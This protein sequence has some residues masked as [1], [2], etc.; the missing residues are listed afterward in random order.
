[1]PTSPT[2]TATKDVF[3]ERSGLCRSHSGINL[4]KKA[5]IRRSYS[6]NDLCYSVNRIRCE[7][8][9]PNLKN[10]LS[11]GIFSLQISSSIIPDSLKSFLYHPELNKDLS[12]ADKD[13]N[14]DENPAEND[15]EVNEIK[16][17]NWVDMLLEIQSLWKLRQQEESVDGAEICDSENAVWDCDDN[18]DEIGCVVNYDSEGGGSKEIYDRE[19]FSKLLVQGPWSDT[20]LF[21]QLAFLCNMAYVIP[22]LKLVH[23]QTEIDQIRIESKWGKVLKA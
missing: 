17:A 12:I 18:G 2:S 7:S 14:F 6:D 4:Y 23:F 8:S 20:K 16:I 5:G 9:K 10:N 15:E 22:E 3:K 13:V 11:V 21:S 19:S 1:M